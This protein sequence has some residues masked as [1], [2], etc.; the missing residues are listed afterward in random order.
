MPSKRIL[1]RSSRINYSIHNRNN[2]FILFFASCVL[3]CYEDH[4]ARFYAKETQ[5]H[6][7]LQKPFHTESR[8]LFQYKTYL[9]TVKERLSYSCLSST[10]DHEWEPEIGM[11]SWGHSW[12]YSAGTHLFSWVTAIDLIVKFSYIWALSQYKDHI[13]RY[14]YSHVKDKTVTRPSYL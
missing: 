11:P 3:S 9:T 2:V 7:H 14:G 10:L 1:F 8:D 12:N 4:A 13:S 6:S 5:L